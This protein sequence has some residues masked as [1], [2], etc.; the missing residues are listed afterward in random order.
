[1]IIYTIYKATNIL[2]GKIYIGQ[3]ISLYYRKNHYKNLQCKRQT[4]LYNSLLKY[5]WEKHIFEIIEEINY[6]D[7]KTFLN[8]REIYWIKE[9]CSFGPNGLNCNIGLNIESQLFLFFIFLSS[10]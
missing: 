9:L 1:M 3:T 7:D 2:N 5:G 4:I 10:S 6:N 8:E